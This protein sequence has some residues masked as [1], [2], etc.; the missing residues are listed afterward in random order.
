MIE[1]INI[2]QCPNETP[3]KCFK[4]KLWCPS[5]WFLLM[6]FFTPSAELIIKEASKS[7]KKKKTISNATLLQGNTLWSFW[8]RKWNKSMK[9][10]CE[11]QVINNE[12][13]FCLL[14]FSLSLSLSFHFDALKILSTHDYVMRSGKESMFDDF[15]QHSYSSLSLLFS[16]QPENLLNCSNSWLRFVCEVREQTNTQK[17]KHRKETKKKNE[18]E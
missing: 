10:K 3:K 8:Q 2:Y 5:V 14:S 6:I 17:T 1:I 12:L 18:N 7:K 16:V 13:F 9:K 15:L 4:H 11:K